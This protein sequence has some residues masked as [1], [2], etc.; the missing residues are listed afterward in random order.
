MIVNALDRC[1]LYEGWVGQHRFNID[2][3]AIEGWPDTFWMD[4]DWPYMK[5][6]LKACRKADED[7]HARGTIRSFGIHPHPC[8][9]VDSAKFACFAAKQY[10]PA[11]PSDV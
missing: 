11:E 3:L 4:A 10:R 6:K 8:F 7:F 5:K 1:V 9:L 2:F